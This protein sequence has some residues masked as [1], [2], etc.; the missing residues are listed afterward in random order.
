MESVKRLTRA[1]L[2]VA[3]AATGAG[4][5]PAQPAQPAQSTA[6]AQPSDAS[7]AADDPFRIRENVEVTATR[8]TIGSAESPASSTVVL[9][10][11][12]ERRDI[13]AVDQALTVVEGVYA[14]RQRGVPDNEVG[15]GMRGFSGRGTGQ[16]RILVLLDGQPVNNAY[17]GAVNWTTLPLGEI[18][19]VEVVRG[20]FSSLYGGSAMGGVVNVISRPIGRRSFDASVQYGTHDT[21]NYAVRG[22]G[23]IGSRLGVAFGYDGLRTGG[24]EAQ[25]VLRTATD[26][27]PT[28]GTQVTGVTKYLTRT[29]TV[30]YAVGMRGPNTYERQAL[31]ARGE[32]TFGSQTI[33]SFQFVRQ[34]NEYGWDPYR[35]T[36]RTPDGQTLDTGAVVF[37]DGTA[38]KRTTI[39]PSNYLGVVG[40]GTSQVYQGQILHS[41]GAGGQLR[42][43]GGVAR[44]PRDWSG[45]PGTSAVVSG[46]AGTYSLQKNSGAFA[47]VQWSRTMAT[48][49]GLALGADLRRDQASI[50]VFPT[51]NYLGD[52]TLSPRDTFTHGK[53]STWALYAQDQWSL[54]DNVQL[55]FGARYDAWRT[56]DGESQPAAGAATNEFATRSAGAATGKAALVYRASEATTIRTSV[57]TAFRSPSVFDLYRDLRLSSGS[58]LLGN[59]NVDP[60]RM[61]SWEIGV[62]QTVGAPLAF[63]AAYYENRIR[64]LIFRSIDSSDPSGLT[65]RMANA[66]QARTRGV[67]FAAT[68]RPVSWFTAKPTYTFTDAIISKNAFSPAT[69]G[70]QI[71]FVPRHVAAGTLTAVQGAWT[72]TGTGR[73]QTAVFSSDTNTDPV[74]HVPGAYDQ[75]FETDLAVNWQATSHVGV[76]LSVE[77]LFDRQYYLFYR[78]PGRVAMMGLRLHY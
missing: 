61:T 76:N 55:T 29:G 41:L 30:N 27:T 70:K 18:D 75:F 72:V 22:G 25:E 71:P 39:T 69:V 35:S 23:R 66:G 7:A 9:R 14:Y 57:G 53:A 45:T 60:E 67:E 64:D 46:G 38:W 28:G 49:H 32:Y 15:I 31:R 51:T 34:S 11:D 65:Q 12:M 58:L 1:G 62:R 37:L 44:T 54:R 78:S 5:Q 6:A 21:W 48:R 68:W 43:Q 59:P 4:A 13:I 2:L 20:P 24:Y 50:T 33:G 16:S 56:Y 26:S 63:D 40:G 8:S 52:G 77:N 17:T 47:N 73:Y 10:A 42:V 74:K 19:R 36:V 3:L